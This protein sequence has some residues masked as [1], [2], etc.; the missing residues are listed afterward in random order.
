LKQFASTLFVFE[1]FR[2]SAQ[3]PPRSHLLGDCR[4]ILSV[5]NK[6]RVGC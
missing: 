1:L 3:I 5:E 4:K 2:K 6:R